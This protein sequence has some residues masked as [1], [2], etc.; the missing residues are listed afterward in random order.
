MSS[1]SV[2]DLGCP[3]LARPYRFVYRGKSFAR[4]AP[5]L[6]PT[7]RP[8]LCRFPPQAVVVL[9]DDLLPVPGDTGHTLIALAAELTRLIAGA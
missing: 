6:A 7:G 5:T 9:A 4:V 3:P 2:R 1:R 8:H